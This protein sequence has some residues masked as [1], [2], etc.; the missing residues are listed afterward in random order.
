MFLKAVV[1]LSLLLFATAIVKAAVEY[2]VEELGDF[3]P[4]AINNRGEV[5]G[6]MSTALQIPH[7]ALW[8]NGSLID[9]GALGQGSSTA[10]GINDNGEIVGYSK[11]S[12]DSYHTFLFR[13]GLMTDL[14]VFGGIN[15]TAFGINNNG[16]IAANYQTSDGINH[17]ILYDHGSITE[18]G[19]LG[20]QSAVARGID[21]MGNIMGTADDING[22]FRAFVYTNGEMLDLGFPGTSPFVYGMNDNM[23]IVG[24]SYQEGVPHAFIYSSGSLS[25]IACPDGRTLAISVNNDGEIVGYGS[26]YGA[27]IYKNG[28]MSNL[29]ELIDPLLGIRITDAHGINDNGQIVAMGFNKKEDPTAFLLT[30]IPEPTITTLLITGIIGII[31]YWRFKFRLHS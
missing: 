19:T 5:V 7:A 9:L 2:T 18:L 8:S 16:Q 26:T 15:S 25:E 24:S 6:V 10:E 3:Y 14:G 31:C 22:I 21:A 17:A 11:V 4:A 12:A 30:P 20:G 27:F 29:E 13:N 23:Q 1:I 28:V